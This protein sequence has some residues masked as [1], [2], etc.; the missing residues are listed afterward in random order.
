MGVQPGRL[1]PGPDPFS[2]LFMPDPAAFH[3]EVLDPLD[4]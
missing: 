2:L 3:V 1:A 4:P